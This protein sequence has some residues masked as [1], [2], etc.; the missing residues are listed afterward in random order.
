M[1][2]NW[3]TDW[4]NV[5]VRAQRVAQRNALQRAEELAQ[6]RREQENVDRAVEQLVRARRDQSGSTG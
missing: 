3:L 5:P 2:G 4:I 1:R 6:R